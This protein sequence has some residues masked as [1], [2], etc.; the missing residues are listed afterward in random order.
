MRTVLGLRGNPRNINKSFLW[1]M[2]LRVKYESKVRAQSSLLLDTAVPHPLLFGWATPMTLKGK[3]SLCVSSLQGP[4]SAA[5]SVCRSTQ[6]FLWKKGFVFLFRSFER[7][8]NR[9]MKQWLSG[10]FMCFPGIRIMDICFASL[11]ITRVQVWQHLYT[12]TLKNDTLLTHRVLAQHN[13][14]TNIVWIQRTVT[15]CCD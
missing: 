10:H 5:L 15:S 14:L 6:Q 1:N 12:V 13:W 11:L 9:L 4:T 2:E 8:Q 7:L 3:R